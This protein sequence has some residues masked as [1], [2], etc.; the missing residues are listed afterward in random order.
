MLSHFVLPPPLPDEDIRN[1]VY[2]HYKARGSIHFDLMYKELFGIRSGFNAVFPK[3]IGDMLNK[4]PGEN[5]YVLAEFLMQHSYLP[6]VCLFL[7]ESDIQNATQIMDHSETNDPLLVGQNLIVS[8]EIN[9]CPKCAYDDYNMYGVT[10]VHRIHQIQKMDICKIHHVNLISNCPCCKMPLANNTK[11]NQL[12]IKPSC[13]SCGALLIE[14]RNEV[15]RTSDLKIKILDDIVFLFSNK[16]G[17]LNIEVLRS[18]NLHY[19]LANNLLRKKGVFEDEKYRIL[20]NSHFGENN[21]KEIGITTE[22]SVMTFSLSSLGVK[23]NSLLMQILNMRFFTGSAENFILNPL[24]VIVSNLPPWDLTYYKCPNKNCDQK[25]NTYKRFFDKKKQV[26][27]RKYTCAKC[28]IG[29]S[30]D[31][32]GGFS[33]ITIFKS[34]DE[35]RKNVDSLKG[36]Y[37]N[38]RSKEWFGKLIQLYSQHREYKYVASALRCAPTTVKKYLQIYTENGNDID[39]LLKLTSGEK[40]SY[41]RINDLREKSLKIIAENSDINLTQLSLAIGKSSYDYMIKHDKEWTKENFPPKKYFSKSKIK[42]V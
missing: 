10:Y 37:W 28:K 39:V 17:L 13:T 23:Q 41:S 5:S 31:D 14:Y 38:S 19:A 1:I 27:M 11:R 35:I 2:R 21:L 18:K 6:L 33:K 25:F 3:N 9:Y 30:T 36:K 40:Y 20:I 8:S 7:E 4:I 42:N 22:S 29:F 26:F 32:E 15:S 16:L 34:P 24:P 12:L